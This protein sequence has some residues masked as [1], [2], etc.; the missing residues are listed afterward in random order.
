M[1]HAADVADFV[2]APGI[3]CVVNWHIAA[4]DEAGQRERHQRP[5]QQAVAEAGGAVWRKRPRRR[6]TVKPAENH[7]DD[8]QRHRLAQE[9]FG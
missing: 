5:V 6:P 7:R 9:Q 8:G 3:V 1:L 2:A 4:D